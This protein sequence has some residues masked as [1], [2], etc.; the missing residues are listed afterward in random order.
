MSIQITRTTQLDVTAT[1]TPIVVTTNLYENSH[2]QPCRS[3]IVITQDI[4]PIP[5]WFINFPAIVYSLIPIKMIKNDPTQ[6]HITI[7]HFM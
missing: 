3:V 2:M 6:F 5:V 7:W 1:N 4:F